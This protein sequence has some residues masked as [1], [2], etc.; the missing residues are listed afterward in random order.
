MLQDSSD[1]RLRD[2]HAVIV[3]VGKAEVP[4]SCY[5]FLSSNLICVG[6]VMLNGHM[7]ICM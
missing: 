7:Y 3:A 4:F 6:T 1:Y 5:G 2:I